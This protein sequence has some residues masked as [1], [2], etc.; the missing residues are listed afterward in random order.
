[1]D[2]HTI[3]ENQFLTNNSTVIRNV[4]T[5]NEFADNAGLRTYYDNINKNS[6]ERLV[7]RIS[8][9][10]QQEVSSTD[11]QYEPYIIS[12]STPVSQNKNHTL[13]AIWVANQ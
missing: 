12:S 8:V 5:N 3:I 11:F 2:G 9:L 6:N 10:E 1:M 4:L 7:F 13:T